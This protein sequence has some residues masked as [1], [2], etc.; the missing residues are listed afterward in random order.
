MNVGAQVFD[1][2]M[3]IQMTTPDVR[4]LP[5]AIHA[6]RRWQTDRSPIQLH[7]G[8]LGWNVRFGEAETAA[9]VRVW[10][11]DSGILAVGFL[12]GPGLVRLTVDP[13]RRDDVRLAEELADGVDGI[14]PSGT[15]SVEAPQDAVLHQVLGARG[16]HQGESWT[17][18]RRNLAQPVLPVSLRVETVGADLAAARA[19]VHRAAFPNSTFSEQRWQVMAAGTAYA[20]ARCLLG[21]DANGTPVAAI[22]VWSAGAGRPGL[23]E[24]MGVHLDH[25]GH[26]YGTEITLAGALALRELGASSAIVATPSANVGA[27]ATYRAAGFEAQTERF[28]RTRD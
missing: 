6:V 28:D 22:T 12:D 18:L 24:P 25:R 1:R 2:S 16:W 14:F 10:S 20:D 13:L 11:G 3:T 21:F 7:P 17:P 4:S 19:T 23:I 5:D 8:D 15:A 26:G 9:A 27:V